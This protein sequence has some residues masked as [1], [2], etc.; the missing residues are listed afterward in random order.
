MGNANYFRH[1]YK[2][3]RALKSYSVYQLDKEHTATNLL[4]DI[5][6]IEQYRNKSNATNI[7]DYLRLRTLNNWQFCE[8]VTGLRL[9]KSNIF[10]GDR[11]KDGK[12]SMLIFQFNKDRTILFIDV[13]R[14]F[15]P[16]N[17]GMLGN[18]LYGHKYAI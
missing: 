10:Y 13:F 5:L 11:K 9:F 7:Q 17:K 16:F 12:K 2:L 14:S 1:V 3:D 4:T 18:I 15:Y 8:Q 6:R